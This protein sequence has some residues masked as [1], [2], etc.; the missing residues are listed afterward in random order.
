MSNTITSAQK[1]FLPF[2]GCLEHSFIVESIMEDS[3][4]EQGRQN[5]MVRFKERVWICSTSHN[6][7]ND[8]C[9]V[10]SLTIY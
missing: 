6:V 7:V 3:K 9:T 5:G 10:S 4:E 8:G 1:G 2:E